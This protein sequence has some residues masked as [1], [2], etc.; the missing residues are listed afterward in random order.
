MLIIRIS[1]IP[2]QIVKFERFYTKHCYNFLN[3]VKKQHKFHKN[4]PLTHETTN[5]VH[6][7]IELQSFGS[8]FLYEV[9]C[10]I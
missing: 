5:L 8:F 4:C 6:F 2:T 1:D 9:F 10:F 7:I 3:I